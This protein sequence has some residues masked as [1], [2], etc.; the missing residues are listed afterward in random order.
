M[1]DPKKKIVAYLKCKAFQHI[2]V[3]L[4]LPY[5]STFVLPRYVVFPECLYHEMLWVLFLTIDFFSVYLPIYL[6]EVN[7]KYG[8][9][10]ETYVVLT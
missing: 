8:H 1:E 2:L 10:Q 6:P 7:S 9:V 3:Y 4:F 5:M